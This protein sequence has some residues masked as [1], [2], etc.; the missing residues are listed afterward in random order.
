M[1][2]A[3]SIPAEVLK[4]QLH[5]CL[6]VPEQVDHARSIALGTEAQKRRFYRELDDMCDGTGRPETFDSWY[7]AHYNDGP[8]PVHTR[9]LDSR[10]YKGFRRKSG[11]SGSQIYQVV[12]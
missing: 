9:Y 7:K 8:I 5:S 3:M 1:V 4:L 2:E 11:G 12:S 10:S 6:A